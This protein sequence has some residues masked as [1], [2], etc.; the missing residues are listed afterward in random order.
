MQM[1]RVYAI[2][3]NG[4]GGWS[5]VCILLGSSG[6]MQEF[7]SRLADQKP[8]MTQVTRWRR[9]KQKEA[10]ALVEAGCEVRSKDF[11]AEIDWS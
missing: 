7:M 4:N 10:I 2:E 3:T 9:L 6:E 11:D 8:D 5:P 1:N